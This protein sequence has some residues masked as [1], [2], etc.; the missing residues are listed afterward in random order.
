MSLPALDRI[1]AGNRW[2]R[3]PLAEK[4]TF[5]LG[6]LALSLVLPPWAAA[7]LVA[8][9][10]LLATWVGAGIAPR[11]WA[12]YAALPL[13]FMLTGAATLL[14]QV[15]GG[16]GLAP[17]GPAAALDLVMRAGTGL[18]CMLFL[19]MTTPVTDLV[20]GMGRL[21]LPREIGDVAL[22]THRFIFLVADAAIAMSHAQE[23]RLGRIT[24]RRWIVSLGQL[25]AGLLPRSLDRARRMETGLAARGWQGEMKVLSQRPAARP[26]VLAGILTLQGCLLT[27]GLMV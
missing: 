19:S 4:V 24:T 14:V 21:G 17:A 25:T 11:V 20:A 10:V 8:P 9:V 27:V 23:A 6:M 5:A 15:G 26:A 22:L 2:R 16:I 3:A 7:V 13:G 1:A 18:S 12:A